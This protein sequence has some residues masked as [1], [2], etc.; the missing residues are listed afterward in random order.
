[1]SVLTVS[2]F[3]TGPGF[4]GANT[5]AIT[6]AFFGW[7]GRTDTD[8]PS[9]WPSTAVTLNAAAAWTWTFRSCFWPT[10]IPP[11]RTSVDGKTLIGA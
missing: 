5:I 11:N 9:P 10:S 6:W 4:S 1:M 8:T 3:L 7:T 2:T